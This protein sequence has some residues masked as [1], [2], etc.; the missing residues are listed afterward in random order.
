MEQVSIVAFFFF[1]G[2]SQLQMRGGTHYTDS[3]GRFQAQ[4]AGTTFASVLPLVLR[5]CF[6][7]PLVQVAASYCGTDIRIG[8]VAFSWPLTGIMA[9]YD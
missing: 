7:L 2:Q 5:Y 1:F 8:Y 3:P 9:C 4:D 6:S